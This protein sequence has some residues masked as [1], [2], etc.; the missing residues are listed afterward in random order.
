[1]EAREFVEHLVARHGIQGGELKGSKLLHFNRGRKAIDE[2]LST[3]EK[4]LKFQS[5]IKNMHLRANFTNI[6]LSL[7]SLK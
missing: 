6:F 1:V 3:F 5:R 7:A 2:V 4:K